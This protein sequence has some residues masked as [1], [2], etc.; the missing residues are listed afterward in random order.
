MKKE[1]NE[2]IQEVNDIASYIT[3]LKRVWDELDSLSSNIKCICMCV[4]EG[5]SKLQKS[6]EDQRIIQ[7]LMGLNEVY[8]H[9]RGNILMMNPLPSI[10]LAYSMLLQDENQR[11]SYVNP[12]NNSTVSSF[13]ATGQGGYPYKKG[14]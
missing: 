5:K 12:T 4:C 9:A 11:E 13:M 8:S 10:N 14:K 6:L 2:S 1:L 3:K 7:F